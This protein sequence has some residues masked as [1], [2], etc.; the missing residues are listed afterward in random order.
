MKRLFEISSEEKQRILEMH[1]TATKKNYLSEQVA[2]QTT[3]YPAPSNSVVA[4]FTKFGKINLNDIVSKFKKQ[5]QGFSGDFYWFAG[6]DNKG[7]GSGDMF[8]LYRLIGGF[9]MDSGTVYYNPTNGWFVRDKPQEYAKTIPPVSEVLQNLVGNVNSERTYGM[10]TDLKKINNTTYIEYLK[11]YITTNPNSDVAIALR[12]PA[13]KIAPSESVTSTDIA[14][15]KT[16]PIYTS[17]A[18]TSTPST[19]TPPTQG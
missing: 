10:G 14:K 5:E 3:K 4:E 2:Q 15:I 8:Y 19:T 17:L 7:Y 16:N 12:T 13:E 1:E 6:S 11:N 9:L 18:K